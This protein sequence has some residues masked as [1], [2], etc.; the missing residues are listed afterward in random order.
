MYNFRKYFTISS[1]K[2]RKIS[3]ELSILPNYKYLG[4]GLIFDDDREATLYFN[5]IFINIW[6]TLCNIIPYRPMRYTEAYGFLPC[7]KEICI[8]IDSDLYIRWSMW[9]DPDNYYVEGY[10]NTFRKGSFNTKKILFGKEVHSSIV[11]ESCNDVIYFPNGTYIAEIKQ[12]NNI[13]T[14]PRWFT[15]KYIT[16]QIEVDFISGKTTYGIKDKKVET[17]KDALLYIIKNNASDFTLY[18][19]YHKVKPNTFKMNDVT[20]NIWGKNDREYILENTNSEKCEYITMDIVSFERAR[21]LDEI[22]N[23]F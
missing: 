3:L 12:Y 17:C 4:I 18:S 9:I 22:V 7:D 1:K 6:F 5:F 2:N 14:R 10:I 16:Y 23:M 20:Y 11:T 21:K 13:I 15:T 8:R 19:R